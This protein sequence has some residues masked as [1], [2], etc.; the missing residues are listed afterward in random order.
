MPDRK[1]SWIVAILLVTLGLFFLLVAYGVYRL[2]RPG[3]VEL[4]QKSVLEIDL[5]MEIPEL[6]PTS[7]LAQLVFR[8][9]VSMVDLNRVFLAAAKDPQIASLYLSIHPLFM[10]WAQVEEL[11]AFLKEFRKS[12]K[13][14][15]AH[16]QLDMAEEKELYLASLADQIYLNPDAGLLING[17]AAEIRFYKRLMERLKVE[18]Q[19]L[20]F[21]EFKSPE[22][23]TREGMTPE[24]RSMLES[25]LIDI[26]NRFLRTVAE[27]RQIDHTRLQELMKTGL[28][29]ASVALK[30]RLVTALGYED[31]VQSKLLVEI[32]G[33]KEYRAISPSRYLKVIDGRRV[34]RPR[35][36]VAL[37]GGLGPITSGSSDEFLNETMG[38]ETVAA[39]LR[40]I[41]KAK[42]IQGVLF[43]VDSP[44]GSAV[45][46]DKIW[47]EVRLLESNGKPVV[48]SMSGVAGSGGY[49]IAMGA[50]KIVAL[51]STITGSIGVIFGKF[52][53]RGLFEQWLGITTDEIRLAENATIFSPT[54]S[55]SEAQKNQIRSWMEEIYANFVRKAAEGRGMAFEQLE[56]KAH[57]RIYTGAQAK[58]LQLIDE[59]GGLATA[60]SLLKKE[61]KIP[62]NEEVELVLYP[63]PKSFW[64]ALSE[65]DFFRISLPRTPVES[66]RTLMHS[67]ET[68][69]PWLLAP[70]ISIR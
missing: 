3:Q 60:L 48:A 18:P 29:P 58:E 66:V 5:G 35:H 12:N 7:S 28:A 67:L 40:E 21:K 27:E 19:F 52:N 16:L 17:L 13:K 10:P 42:D 34:R 56:A 61:L 2:V 64:K 49:Y 59:V 45:G 1:T 54:Q 41:R 50:R 36:R 24:F 53:V 43:R 30:E 63:K 14:I 25:I 9:A 39:R 38:G 55:L 8:D 51:P 47:R 69:A 46:S 70:E 62:E 6:P 11:R 65:G 4:T 15:F 31:E 26:Q 23:F 37:L 68:P 22:T 33:S 44:G 32:A 57:G 20:Q